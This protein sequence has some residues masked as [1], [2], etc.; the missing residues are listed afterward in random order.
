M[1]PLMYA[2]CLLSVCIGSTSFK[3]PTPINTLYATKDTYRILVI[4]TKYAM[5]IFDSTGECLA[6]YPVVFGNKDMG[7]KMMQGDRRTPEG[8]FKI[9]FKRKHEKWSR[10]LLI[11]YPNAESVAK[12]NQRKAAGL[13]PSNA[14]IGGSIGI[15]GTWPNEDF[16]IDGLQNWTEGCISTKNRYVEEI[17]DVLPVGTQITIRREK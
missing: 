3:T 9:S 8:T 4:K 11:D 17:F 2:T 5:K 7:D 16:A 10:F 15:H 6:T 12:F 1:R 14:Q 13:I